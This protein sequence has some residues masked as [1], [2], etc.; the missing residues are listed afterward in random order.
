KDRFSNI[1]ARKSGEGKGNVMIY[2]HI[3]EVGLIIKHIDEEGFLSF[4]TL[5][6]LDAK[7]LPSQRVKILV[8]NGFITGVIGCKP[9]HLQTQKEMETP[10]KIEDLFIDV[11]AANRKEA[12]S[13]GIKPGCAAA[14]ERS[15]EKIGKGNLVSGKALDD[16]VGCA[17]MVKVAEEVSR[18]KFD[19]DL[20]FGGTVQEE[21]GLRGSRVMAFSIT[22]SLGLVIDTSTAGDF[23]GLNLKKA[24]LKVGAG[25]GIII[26]DSGFMATEEVKELMISTA[27]EEK[28][29]YQPVVV[30]GGTTDAAYIQLTKEGVPVG[31]IAVPSRYTH[32]TIEVV[33]LEDVANT[34]KLIA[35]ILKRLNS[36]KLNALNKL[37]LI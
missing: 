30:K 20:Y 11:G 28:I 31:S 37:K 27:E 32:S 4:E 5:G 16:R 19:F 22:P 34:V 17:I 7:I 15:L 18:E 35:A 9:P 6:G 29:P 1:V 13:W 2:A 33:S 10:Y 12:E 24:P 14:L 21:L 8:K 3:D 25:P 26:M 36:E 23:P